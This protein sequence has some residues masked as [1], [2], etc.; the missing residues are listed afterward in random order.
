[1]FRVEYEVSIS[2]RRVGQEAIHEL[3]EA[4]AGRRRFARQRKVRFVSGVVVTSGRPP[5]GSP[6]RSRGAGGELSAGQLNG[7]DIAV[8]VAESL[9]AWAEGHNAA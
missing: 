7:S 4:A 8:A 6:A 2:V 5:A 9:L 3:L 1:M